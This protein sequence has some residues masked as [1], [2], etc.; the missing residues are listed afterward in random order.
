M[1]LLLSIQNMFGHIHHFTA[2][3]LLT[4]IARSVLLLLLASVCVW[5]LTKPALAQESWPGSVDTSFTPVVNGTVNKILVQ[6]QDSKILIFGNF[7]EVNGV[8]RKGVARLLPDG[9]LDESFVIQGVPDSNPAGLDL[10]DLRDPREAAF[11]NGYLLVLPRG[12][13]PL[14]RFSEDGTLDTN[15]SPDPSVQSVSGF[16]VQPDG[17]IVLDGLG[18]GQVDRLSPNVLLGWGIYRLLPDGNRD[19]SFTFNGGG[20]SLVALAIQSDGKLIVAGDIQDEQA[21]SF[22]MVRLNT[23]GTIDHT[24]VTD[25]SGVYNYCG[26]IHQV[27]VQQDDKILLL[28]NEMYSLSGFLRLNANGALDSDFMPD[29]GNYGLRDEKILGLQPDGKILVNVRSEWQQE[30]EFIVWNEVRVDRLENDGSIDYSFI[31]IGSGPVPGYDATWYITSGAMQPDGKLVVGGSAF[32]FGSSNLI[33]LYS[34]TARIQLE[35]TSLQFPTEVEGSANPAPL[36]TNVTGATSSEQFTWTAHPDVAWLRA[37]PG[38]GTTPGTLQ[39][40]ADIAELAPGQHQGHLI[41]ESP[42]PF[43]FNS[44]Q[45]VTVS[46]T[47]A[48]RNSGVPVLRVDRGSVGFQ[49]SY[50][51]GNPQPQAFQV[52]NL[53]GGTLQWQA[54]VS[55][56]AQPWLSLQPSSGSGPV[57]VSMRVN[58]NGLTAGNYSSQIVVRD[59]SGQQSHTLQVSLFVEAAPRLGIVPRRLVFSAIKNKTD[60]PPQ[61]VDITNLGGSN[62]IWQASESSNWLSLLGSTSGSAPG[63]LGIA[64]IIA[65]LNVGQYSS[66]VTISGNAINSP[67]QVDIALGILT[68][69]ILDVRGSPV[70]FDTILGQGKPANKQITI[71]NGGDTDLLWSASEDISWLEFTTPAAG[72]LNG[73]NA[74]TSLGLSVT[75]G[76]LL[77]GTYRGQI[78]VR[79]SNG[80]G[81]PQTVNVVLTIASPAAYCNLKGTQIELF[82]T[83]NIRAVIENAQRTFTSSG[84][85]VSGTLS[86]YLGSGR[87]QKASLSA[88][89]SATVSLGNVLSGSATSSGLYLTVANFRLKLSDGFTVQ[90]NVG[91]TFPSGNWELPALFGGGIKGLEGSISIG[92]NGISI[93]GKQTFTL[94]D[95]NWGVMAFTGNTAIARFSSDSQFLLDVTSQKLDVKIS[96]GS[97]ASARNIT[98]QLNRDGIRTASIGTFTLPNVGGVSLKVV[99]GRI[100][101]DT[102]KATEAR[103]VIPKEWGGTEAALFGLSISKTGAISISGGEF[104]LPS[105]AA[106]NF[107]LMTLKG[108]F[109]SRNGGGYTIHAAGTFSMSQLSN[110]RSCS[111]G[112]E[113]TLST[114]PGGA[115]LLNVASIE[116]QTVPLSM[117]AT[118]GLTLDQ[119]A[120]ELKCR[121]GIAIGT[122]SFYLTGIR[123]DVT[124]TPGKQEVTLTLWIEWSAR[125]GDTSVIT[126]IPSATIRPRPFRLDFSAPIQVLGKETNEVTANFEDA[127]FHT[128]LK[129]DYVVIHAG[130][131]AEA[132]VNNRRFYFN[133]S[134]WADVS[135]EKGTVVNQCWTID[136]YFGSKTYCLRVPDSDMRLAKVDAYLDLSRVAGRIKILGYG[137]GFTYNFRSGAFSLQNRM[138]TRMILGPEIAAAQERWRTMQRGGTVSRE[139]AVADAR[140]AF[141]SDGAVLVHTPV[142]ALTPPIQ[143]RDAISGFNLQL[144][145]DVIF[146]M[147]QP[148][149][150]TLEFSVRTPSGL[151]ITR[152]YLNSCTPDTDAYCNSAVFQQSTGISETQTLYVVSAAEPGEWQM[153]IQ[154]D[155]D[156]IPYDFLV[157]DISNVP[158]PQWVTPPTLA[159]TA[160][161][162]VQAQWQVLAANPQTTTVSI[163]A[164]SGDVTTTVAYTDSNGSLVSGETMLYAGEPLVSGLRT[165]TTGQVETRSL[166]LRNLPSG[167]YAFW[168]R[169]D[170][171]ENAPLQSYLQQNGGI[172]RMSVDHT[173]SFPG[174]TRIAWTTPI[175]PVM[176]VGNGRIYVEWNFLDHPD[177]DSYSLYVRSTDPLSPTIEVTRTLQ[178][179]AVGDGEIGG[180]Y[181][182]MIEP[183]HTYYISIGAEDIETDRIAWSQEIAVTA[184]QPEFLIGLGAVITP[185]ITAGGDPL[186]LPLVLELDSS[187]PYPVLLEVDYGRLADGFHVI[188]SRD[189]ITPDGDVGVTIAIS[190][191]ETTL[192]GYYAVPVLARSGRLEHELS[193]SIEVKSAITQGDVSCDDKAS[194]VDALFIMQMDAGMRGAS[195][196]CPPAADTLFTPACDVNGDNKC[197][198]VDA[199]FIMQCDAG[200]SN[201]FC[202]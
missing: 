78:T 27:V 102:I 94:P 199:L 101:K 18:T 179:G 57:T 62:L 176:D 23:N 34:Y 69:P 82:N 66:Q 112:V 77:P 198:L 4:Q 108:S 137:A 132:G 129:F 29:I 40:T 170:D 158:P 99:G 182:D 100:E 72:S 147:V 31:S 125:I 8:A 67:V 163:F 146:A 169:V 17:K 190:V 97:N 14:V 105:I 165:N 68:G 83:S 88:R 183:G 189:V 160:P 48:P 175:T 148:P 143:A 63:S 92:P 151:T 51:Q 153:R 122:T 70:T 15:F 134:G 95:L 28:M 53:G 184:P 74:S 180:M 139:Y 201:T 117:A 93:A 71:R 110:S 25:P 144:R 141:E 89:I 52:E 85:T 104:S 1:N 46:I 115:S 35:H 154:G 49:A 145:R 168:M 192:P 167:N 194:L 43:V 6:P 188:F 138:Q 11:Q 86:V 157:G 81:S 142:T 187:L 37:E 80:D 185:T 76:A 96:G 119:V 118:D 91:I 161:G 140:F 114:G 131:T 87:Q 12:G 22:G 159:V 5:A 162:Q 16:L 64:A 2:Q 197:S 42:E 59:G 172:T 149:T 13:L 10:G 45:T 39:V 123:G 75:P 116:G 200:I 111:I 150:S 19:P 127:R 106:G 136:Y 124:L 61:S 109:K 178:A 32:F 41:V 30:E 193:L 44:P 128:E 155:T 79:S 164:T 202:P 56:E 3:R 36:S 120:V 73:R 20:Y 33:R 26:C 191:S 90:E 38:I 135:V 60:P 181:V 84:C 47:I 195:G 98:M 174:T 133:G 65:G 54:S 152:N 121:P 130:L 166:D 50:G 171:G 196:S 24:F 126:A 113:V 9:S 156:T 186:S 58:A 103:I 177:V 55:T 107:N 21:I 173:N 7:T